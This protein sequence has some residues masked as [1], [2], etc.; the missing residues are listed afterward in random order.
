MNLA[1]TVHLNKTGIAIFAIGFLLIFY[2]AFLR[3]TSSMNNIRTINLKE[4]LQTSIL[5][6]NEG[7][8]EVL[9]YKNTNDIRS[10]G[11]TKEGAND[12]VTMADLKSHCV[13]M[14]T[15]KSYDKR[16][17]VISEE[18]VDKCDYTGSDRI[19][20]LSEIDELVDVNVPVDD[21][22]VW[23]DP[24]DATQE[25]TE[26]L[27]HYVTTMVCVAVK[28]R[29]VIGVIY[30]PLIKKWYWGWVGVGLSD[31]NIQVKAKS[32]DFIKIIVSRS[33]KGAVEEMI[34]SSQLKNFKITTAGGAGYKVLEVVKGEN[35][36]YI[37]T[38]N[39]KK[40][41]ICAG[42]A[43]LDALGGKMVDLKG[44]LIDYG[45]DSNHIHEN[46]LIASTKS[47]DIYLNKFVNN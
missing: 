9:K 8:L 21:V 42:N 39:I 5:A 6:A 30:Q 33:H 3:D 31:K 40:W 17:R 4:L 38:T 18:A 41:D 2:Y 26:G 11:K 14:G 16:I 43:I 22:T 36:V 7:G 15:I 44:N 25:F 46:G 47:D 32:D 27:L 35:D 24:L 45:Y 12:S 19:I 20:K 37:H 23:I 28:N 10:K 13:M 1:G 34:K 29:A